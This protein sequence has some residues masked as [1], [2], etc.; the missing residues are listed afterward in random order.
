MK[1]KIKKNTMISIVEIIM[2]IIIL[3]HDYRTAFIHRSSYKKRLSIRNYLNR[4]L[5][6]LEERVEATHFHPHH[7]LSFDGK[8]ILKLC[9]Y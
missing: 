1:K 4:I 6:D 3:C 2:S 8:D 7:D 5:F 9:S